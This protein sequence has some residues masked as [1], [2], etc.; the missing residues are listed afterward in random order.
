M[1]LCVLASV[2]LAAIEVVGMGAGRIFGIAS[3][4]GRSMG[5]RQRGGRV[6]CSKMVQVR[7]F[8]R[9]ATSELVTDPTYCRLSSTQVSG[10][11]RFGD[12]PVSP[13]RLPASLGSRK[14]PTFCVSYDLL[15]LKEAAWAKFAIERRV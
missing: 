10:S 1:L 11:A 8:R 7:R 2:S 12:A 5:G 3:S 14:L 4:I 15:A 13:R 6:N 9:G